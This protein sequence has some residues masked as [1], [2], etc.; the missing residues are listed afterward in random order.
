MTNTKELVEKTKQLSVEE[1]HDSDNERGRALRYNDGKLRYDLVQGDAHRDMVEVLTIGAKKYDARNWE[2]GMSWTT[3][4]ASMKRHI[5]AIERGEDYD[6]ESGLL[7]AAHVQCNAHFLNAYYYL[8]PQGDDR[9]KKFFNVPKIGL[10]VDEV[11]ADW[12]SAWMKRWKIKDV[13]KSWFFDRKIKDRFER[14]RKDGELDDFYMN[15]DMLTPPSEIPFEP[16]CYIT[17]RP[18]DVK[19][20]MAWL[21]KMGYPTKPVYSV[22]SGQSKV[23]VA[24]EVGIEM[25]VD[26]SYDNFVQLNNNGIF[27]Y[28]FD[29][30]HNHRYNVG[31]LRINS[32]REIPMFRDNI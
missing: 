1:K 10:D 22:G 29:K 24:N 18:V 31:H 14:M 26:D 15:L 23:D 7:H 2:N 13:P 9:P 12:V 5:A 19:I 16:H 25:F 20:T 3:V 27:C 32:L 28:L 30:P 21:D 17:S 4:I 11:L 6:P 8:H